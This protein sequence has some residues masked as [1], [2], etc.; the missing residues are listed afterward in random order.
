MLSLAISLHINIFIVACN[1]AR[2]QTFIIVTNYIN[3]SR[4]MNYNRNL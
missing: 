4:K 2:F 1:F 3:I